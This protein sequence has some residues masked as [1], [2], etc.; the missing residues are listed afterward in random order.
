ME[1]RHNNELT[2]TP[3]AGARGCVLIVDADQ[4]FASVLQAYLLLRNWNAVA[5]T[6]REAIRDWAALQPGAVIM[7]FDA[8]GLDGFDLLDW[9]QAGAQCARVVVCSH[10]PEPDEPERE[11]WRELGVARWVR[12]P[13][14]LDAI[15]AG[16]D[17]VYT[18]TVVH[19]AT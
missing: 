15:A 16:L 1:R 12:R 10:Y 9:L 4:T 8:P 7:D 14:S 2:M 18:G 17:D 3:V 19:A 11:S 13:C 5:C 6:G